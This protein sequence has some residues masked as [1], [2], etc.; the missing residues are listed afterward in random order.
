MPVVRFRFKEKIYT[1]TV[2]RNFRGEYIMASKGKDYLF[3]KDEFMDL[4]Y[5][6]YIYGE[7]TLDEK[8]LEQIAPQLEE[9]QNL[10]NSHANYNTQA[11]RKNISKTVRKR[12]SRHLHYAL[13]RC[14]I[15]V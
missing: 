14:A 5:G 9:Y 7:N 11:Q 1:R 6:W 2:K 4:N 8:F 10:E 13:K 12:F 15:L 3:V